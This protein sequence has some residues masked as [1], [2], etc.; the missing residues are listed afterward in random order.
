MRTITIVQNPLYSTLDIQNWLRYGPHP[1]TQSAGPITQV[2]FPF[3]K[4]SFSSLIANIPSDQGQILQTFLDN[5]IYP[6]SGS[7]TT[8]PGGVTN[9]LSTSQEGISSRVGNVYGVVGY[10]VYSQGM[11][12]DGQ[13]F[14]IPEIVWSLMP[15]INGQIEYSFYG[16][17]AYC[18]IQ[19]L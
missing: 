10:Y 3:S 5:R 9:V 11:W 16:S 4:S 6:R 2:I 12:T 19:L 8:I 14:K 7:V 18:F 13:E 1:S 15:R 17:E